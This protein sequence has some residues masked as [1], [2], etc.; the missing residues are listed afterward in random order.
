MMQQVQQMQQAYQQ[1]M[2]EAQAANAQIDQALALLRDDKLRGFRID[3][4]T[5]STIQPDEDAEKQR[6]TEFVTAIG[7]LIQQAVPLVQQV[8]EL[9]PLVGE[10]LLFTA[11]GFRAGR[12]LED[13]IEQAMQAI[14]DRITQQ[15]SQ[16]PAD[17]NAAINEAKAKQMAL[18]AEHKGQMWGME[19][20]HIAQ[21]NALELEAMQAKASTEIGIKQQTAATDLDVQRQQSELGLNTGK[22]K[23][24]E[25][26]LA[27]D[28]EAFMGQPGEQVN[29]VSQVLQQVMGQLIDTLNQSNQSVIASNQQVMQ[30]LTAPK[31]ITAPDGRTYTAQTALN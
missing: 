19:R 9:A 1:Q 18:E 5:D 3:I 12:Q 17:P 4:E 16:Q 15:M 31:V 2:Q 7:G 14:Q 8:P 10:T 25:Q 6:R 24:K 21:K 22:Q 13:Q 23:L 20:D 27:E 29:G 28:Q 26:I 11:R 30:A